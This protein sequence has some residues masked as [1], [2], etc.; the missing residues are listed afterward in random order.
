M[1]DKVNL[2]IVLLIFSVILLIGVSIAWGFYNQIYA[3][4]FVPDVLFLIVGTISFCG[5]FAGCALIFMSTL[6]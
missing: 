3:L 6:D 1:K 2:G 5:A 4:G